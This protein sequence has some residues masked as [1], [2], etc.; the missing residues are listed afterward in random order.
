MQ[1]E[2]DFSRHQSMNTATG[3]NSCEGR[4][5]SRQPDITALPTAE[6]NSTDSHCLNDNA[7]IDT[8]TPAMPLSSR[9]SISHNNAPPSANNSST[10]RTPHTESSFICIF[11]I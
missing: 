7:G 3:Q 6:E 8:L 9:R 5:S 11:S 4:L 10:G 1:R 2:T